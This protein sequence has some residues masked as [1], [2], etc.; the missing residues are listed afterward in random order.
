MSTKYNET[1]THAVWWASAGCLPDS[2]EPVFIGDLRACKDYVEND[3]DGFFDNVGVHNLYNFS[4]EPYE[5]D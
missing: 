2:E 4:I 1:I 3:P 5:E